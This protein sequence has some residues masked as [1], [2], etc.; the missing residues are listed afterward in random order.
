MQETPC[1]I[2]H[3][4]SVG[5]NTGSAQL[6]WVQLI[7]LALCTVKEGVTILHCKNLFSL[8]KTKLQFRS[9]LPEHKNEEVSLGNLSIP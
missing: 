2:F 1:F 5:K 4:H 6:H 9:S 7:L 3:L 8:T